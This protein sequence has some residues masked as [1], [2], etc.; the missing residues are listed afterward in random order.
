MNLHPSLARPLGRGI[1][2]D[3]L[4]RAARLRA[5]GNLTARSA[6]ARRAVAVTSKLRPGRRARP[7]PP[8]LRIVR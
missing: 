1:Q 3:H 2:A 5:A 7:E 8:V 6:T 4:Q